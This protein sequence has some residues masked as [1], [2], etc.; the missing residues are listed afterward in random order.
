[1]TQDTMLVHITAIGKQLFICQCARTGLKHLH[2]I[3]ISNS[4]VSSRLVRAASFSQEHVV[5]PIISYDKFKSIYIENTCKNEYQCIRNVQKAK[6]E[7]ILLESLT[8]P[9]GSRRL[10]PP[11]G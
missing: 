5:I 4:W 8:G 3:I 6:G 7:A 11:R 2:P 9:D 1:M 10:R